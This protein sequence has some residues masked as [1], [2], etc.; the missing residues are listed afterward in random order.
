MRHFGGK[1]GGL[2]V[3]FPGGRALYWAFLHRPIITFF[4]YF[5]YFFVICD[6]LLEDTMN[7]HNYDIITLSILELHDLGFGDS[8]PLLQVLPRAWRRVHQS[9]LIT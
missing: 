6:Y 3:E 8:L 1:L 7:H 4:S 9:S 5:H 2:C